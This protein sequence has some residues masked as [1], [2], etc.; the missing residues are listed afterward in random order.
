MITRI[1]PTP[2]GYLHAGNGAAFVLAWQLAREAGGKLLLRIDDLDI[3]R[4]RPEYVQ[5]IFDTLVWL[6]IDWDLGPRDPWQLAQSWSQHLRMPEYNRLLAELRAAGQLYACDCSRS[7]IAA[8]AS[9]A[10]YDGHCRSRD[11]DLDAPE[12]AWRLRIPQGS[13]LHMPV[14]PSR[15]ARQYE[16]DMPDPV[17]RQRNGRPAYQIASLSDDL[18]FQVDLVVRGMDLLPSTLVQLH[19]ADVLGRPAF[20]QAVFLHHALLTGPGGGKLSKAAGAESLKHWRETG[21]GPGEV[22]ALAERLRHSAWS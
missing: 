6:G 17:V 13:S 11:I 12:V 8:R 21:R 19:I 20:S 2:S 16:L 5:D 4:V 18:R 22:L 7:Q 1:A 3:E 14:W 9:K 10:E 15:S